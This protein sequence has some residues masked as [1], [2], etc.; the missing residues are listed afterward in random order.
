MWD[1]MNIAASKGV[2]PPDLFHP[3]ISIHIE[4]SIL[5]ILTVIK[6]QIL[7]KRKV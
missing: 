2:V 7:E 4:R 6:N 5:V 3:P 1:T